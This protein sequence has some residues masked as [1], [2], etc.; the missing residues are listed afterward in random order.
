MPAPFVYAFL[1]VPGFRG[2]F[3]PEG[4][5]RVRWTGLKSW[6]RRWWYVLALL[7][8]LVLL[9]IATF[10]IVYLRP[11]RILFRADLEGRD[12]GPARTRALCHQ[13]LRFPG[14]EHDVF[15]H[16]SSVGDETSVTHLLRGLRRRPRGPGLV[17]CTWSHGLEALRAVTNNDPG[18]SYEA[19]R[20]WYSANRRKSRLE[21]I[22]DGFHV[23][24]HAVSAAGGEETVRA[25]LSILGEPLW[26]ERPRPRW[27]YRNATLLLQSF[28][29]VAVHP[30]L[31]R[32]ARAGPVEERRGVALYAS[33]AKDRGAEPLLRELL[34]D[35]D[36]SVRLR[37]GGALAQFEL[38]RL[39]NPPGYLLKRLYL[40][41]E[42]RGR[43]VVS[44]R[45][46]LYYPA[47]GGMLVAYDTA[48]E[49][50][51][52]KLKR[53][54]GPLTLDGGYLFF[55]SG[56]RRRR[57]FCVRAGDGHVVWKKEIPGLKSDKAPALCGG[58]LVVEVNVRDN[59]DEVAL[60][61]KEDAQVVAR[62][63][64]ELLAAHGSTVFVRHGEFVRAL[65]LPD[66]AVRAEFAVKH[67]PLGVGVRGDTAAI[68]LT[69]CDGDCSS[70]R[71]KVWVEGWSLATGKRLYSRRIFDGEVESNSRALPSGEGVLYVC[72]KDLTCAIRVR[73][74]RTLWELALGSGWC[75]DGMVL[76]GDA[77][78]IEHCS[79][80]VLLKA[81][82]TMRAHYDPPDAGFSARHVYLLGERIY[83]IRGGR[84]TDTMY[85]FVMPKRSPE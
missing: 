45:G 60:C 50:A 80:L 14:G 11:R 2:I 73:D 56:T 28:G 79:N 63:E 82:G 81:T 33:L 47:K 83:A 44:K 15:L 16:L 84:R 78:V 67:R 10:H 34:R 3:G 85:I 21:W 17:A 57:L 40:R 43:G 1:R 68:V 7:A 71:A 48:R 27:R 62:A 70:E 58:H 20:D 26:G 76:L 54:A 59:P 25:L 23:Q 36:R 41:H 53:R 24:G 12:L 64:G 42:P 8:G 69:D 32:A 77:L 72:L 74:G 18:T 46:V 52:W 61:R 39:K 49:G 13:V 6:L 9:V 66:L 37:A 22:A 29:P 75:G 4:A 65:S 51:I 38:E 31:E 35:G 19:W 5:T 30:G 55:A